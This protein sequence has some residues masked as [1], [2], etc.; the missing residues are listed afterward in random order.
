MIRNITKAKRHLEKAREII[1]KKRSPF[2]RMKEEEVIEKVRKDR[3]DIWEEKLA[4][5][6]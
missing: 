4:P 3:Q 2:F 5:R 6:S 1:S